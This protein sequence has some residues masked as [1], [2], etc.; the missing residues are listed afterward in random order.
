MRQPD[1]ESNIGNKHHANEIFDLP[2]ALRQVP[3]AL[4]KI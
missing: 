3:A 2:R 4:H 1:L